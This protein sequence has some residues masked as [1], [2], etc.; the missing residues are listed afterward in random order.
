MAA[1]TLTAANLDGTLVGSLFLDGVVLAANMTAG[2]VVYK[3]TNNQIA[4]ATLSSQAASQ[5]LG[6]YAN[7]AANAG[8][9]AVYWGNGTVITGFP[10]L[11]AGTPYYLGSA[12]AIIPF[13]D[14][15]T[16]NWMTQVGYAYSTSSFMVQITIQNLQKA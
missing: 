8:Q 5:V 4:V 9:P 12:G 7:T 15:T 14:L 13:A 11:V 2:L 16:G 10:T 3:D 6:I 1:L